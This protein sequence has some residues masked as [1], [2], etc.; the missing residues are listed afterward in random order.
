MVEYVKRRPTGQ[1][2]Y[3]DHVRHVQAA[4]RGYATPIKKSSMGGYK[5]YK[6]QE[7]E[8]IGGKVYRWYEDKS[9][10]IISVVESIILNQTDEE[11]IKGIQ[12]IR[13]RGR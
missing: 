13:A 11:I 12:R 1:G 10:D 3:D 2:W 9:G 8:G 5:R 7:D 4:K 6:N